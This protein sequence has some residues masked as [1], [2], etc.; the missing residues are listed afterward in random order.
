MKKT[1]FKVP[2]SLLDLQ[3]AILDKMDIP[4][5]VFHRRMID[6]FIGRGGNISPRLLIVNR[7]DPG[8]VKKEVSEQIYL[9]EERESKI[10][11]VMNRYDCKQSVVLFQAMLDYCCMIAPE[12][13]GD[14]GK[15][16]Q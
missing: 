10:H 3:N 1:T 6:D 13:L 2:K 5:T 12:V 8:Y 11:E 15:Y 16:I 7:T 9:D 14:M 4:K